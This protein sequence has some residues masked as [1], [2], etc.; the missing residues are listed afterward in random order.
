MKKYLGNL[1]VQQFDSFMAEHGYKQN[2]NYFS[3]LYNDIFARVYLFY[4]YDKNYDELQFDVIH[5]FT[6]LIF[7]IDTKC[8]CDGDDDFSLSRLSGEEYIADATDKSDVTNCISRM[9]SKYSELYESFFSAKSISEY[10]DKYLIYDKSVCSGK[11]E[12]EETYN[13]MG[14]D[15]IY[16]YL[17]LKEYNSAENE[18]EKYLQMLNDLKTSVPVDYCKIREYETDI[19]YFKNLKNAIISNDVNVLKPEI[20]KMNDNIKINQTKL[21]TY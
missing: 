12:I 17:Y 6:P 1:F 16:I 7:E 21:K 18:I 3:K 2:I 10:L 4:H 9:F 11:E 19:S 8:I 5:S 20:D 14:L 15:F 13:F